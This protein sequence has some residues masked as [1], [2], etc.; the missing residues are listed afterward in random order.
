M[1]LSTLARLPAGH[2]MGSLPVKYSFWTSITKSARLGFSVIKVI[3]GQQDRRGA[4]ALWPKPGQSAGFHRAL[5]ALRLHV[6]PTP[7]PAES[8][9]H[10]PR[11]TVR[12]SIS[13]P[14]SVCATARRRQ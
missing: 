6:A 8:K 10:T 7:P 13:P 9:L 5:I 1:A 4:S 11:Q 3:V 2:V 12:A 14:A